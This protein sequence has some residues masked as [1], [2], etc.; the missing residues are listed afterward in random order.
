MFP[1]VVHVPLVYLPSRGV[2]VYF[3]VLFRRP[4][5]TRFSTFILSYMLEPLTPFQIVP[6]SRLETLVSRLLGL[7][8]RSPGG[9]RF[10]ETRVPSLKQDVKLPLSPGEFEKF[11]PSLYYTKNKIFLVRPML[12]LF[13]KLSSFR[14]PHPHTRH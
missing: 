2:S 13:L 10:P 5:F 3:T 6:T 14:D 12:K 8:S 1:L 11:T 4:S 9:L 7:K